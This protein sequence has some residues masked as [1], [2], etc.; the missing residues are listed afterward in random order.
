M[1]KVEGLIVAMVT[2][3]DETQ[4][5][6]YEATKDLID[7]LIRRGVEGLFILG[8]NGEFHVLTF[9]E[10]VA[11]SK[12]VIEYTAKRVPVYV[13]VGCNGTQETIDLA[14]AVE[15]F[16]P[17]A[18]S[19][20]SPFFIA[21]KQFEVEAHYR[22]IA[23]AVKTPIILYNI[24]ANTGLNIEPSTVKALMDVPNIIGI[25]DSS[26]KMDNLKA[27]VDAADGRD[28]SVLVG[29]DSKILEAYQLGAVGAVAGTA[30]V[31]TEHDLAVIEAFKAGDIAKAE[32]LQKDIDVL[33]GVLK[34]GSVPSVVKRCTTLLGVNVGEARLP[35]SALGNSVDEQLKEALAFYNLV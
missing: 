13:G 26:G 21:P 22:A 7:T 31:I 11:F 8:T 25:K 15:A 32:Q 14:R 9:D 35:V 1:V 6:N 30:N 20:I 12:F 16:G 3:F 5:I 29:S 18:F 19:V 24:P 27:Y 4:A 17:D 2:P 34:L 10:K 28:F 23:N 33:R